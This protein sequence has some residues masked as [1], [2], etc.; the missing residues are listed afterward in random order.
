MPNFTQDD[1]DDVMPDRRGHDFK[2]CKCE[3]CVEYRNRPPYELNQND[4]DCLMRVFGVG[5]EDH[6]DD[7]QHDLDE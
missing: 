7:D 4:L 1:G 3:G 6:V 5:D 2:R